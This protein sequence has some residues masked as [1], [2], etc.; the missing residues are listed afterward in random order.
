MA[1][2]RIVVGVDGSMNSLQAVEFAAEMAAAADAEVV[3]VHALGLLEHIDG[4]EVVPAYPNRHE[5]ERRFHSDW[6]APLDGTGLRVRRILRD[7]EASSVVLAVAEEESAD[8][9]VVGKRGLG[10][11]TL[12]LLGSTSTKVSLGSKVP[13]VVVPMR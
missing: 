11:V 7:G 3:A 12:Q 1:I 4:D 8:L 6:T 13:V 9:I 2:D 5:I 10:N